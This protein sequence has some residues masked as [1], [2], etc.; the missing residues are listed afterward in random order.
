G[1]RRRGP[2]G[3]PRPTGTRPPFRGRLRGVGLTSS[4]RLLRARR[5]EAWTRGR[6]VSSPAVPGEWPSGKAPD[7]GSGDRRFESFL[8]SQSH[9]MW[10]LTGKPAPALVV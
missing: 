5:A 9:E 2:G 10:C 3:R 4:G 6:E 8:A 7:S 1:P